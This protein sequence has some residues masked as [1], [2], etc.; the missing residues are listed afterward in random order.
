[1]SASRVRQLKH[2]LDPATAVAAEGSAV[3][4][5][6]AVK[7]QCRRETLRPPTQHTTFELGVDVSGKTLDVASLPISKVSAEGPAEGPAAAPAEAPPCLD[8]PRL[9]RATTETPHTLATI[10]LSQASLCNMVD[11]G[12]ALRDVSVTSTISTAD[13]RTGGSLANAL[14]LLRSELVGHLVPVF[15]KIRNTAGKPRVVKKPK[16]EDL[17]MQPITDDAPH[18]LIGRPVVL[19]TCYNHD[20]DTATAAATATATAAAT[21]TAAT[22]A[23]TATD[24]SKAAAVVSQGVFAC[25]GIVASTSMFNYP[26]RDERRVCVSTNPALDERMLYVLVLHVYTDPHTGALGLPLATMAPPELRL[27]DGVVRVRDDGVHGLWES[28]FG[29]QAFVISNYEQVLELLRARK[30]PWSD[31]A[32]ADIKQS[33]HDMMRAVLPAAVSACAAT[34]TT[35][36]QQERLDTALATTPMTVKSKRRHHRELATQGI[37]IRRCLLVEALLLGTPLEPLL[38]SQTPTDM[39]PPPRMPLDGAAD[40]Y[41]TL[42]TAADAMFPAATTAADAYAAARV[43]SQQ[44][45]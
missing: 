26:L 16:A 25:L 8:M 1:M 29:W 31:F 39:P 12:L 30:K 43:P 13:S 19:V 32:L 10:A 41:A 3:A 18:A 34:L 35:L 42:K 5:P 17:Y 23:G 27:V 9:A 7:R 37:D 2:R 38:R 24:V 20:T 40:L 44:A 36:R 15:G 22:A 45:A 14:G 21:T 6:P 33:G 4:P 11:L 28:T